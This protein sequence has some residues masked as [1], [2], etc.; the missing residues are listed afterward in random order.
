MMSHLLQS[1]TRLWLRLHSLFH[2]RRLQREME[3]EMR[4]H[5]DQ[6]TRQNLDAGMA[7]EEARYAARRQFGNQTWLKEASRE[8]WRVN[9]IETLM[10]DVRY[11]ARMMWKAPGFTVAAS[12]TLALGIGA[13]TAIFSVV[14]AVLIHSLPYAEAERLV[15]VWEKTRVNEQ[16]QINIGNFLDWKEQ[17]NV[18]TDMAAFVDAR[19]ILTGAGEPEE[20]PAQRA[21]DNLFSVLGV[22]P[23][24]GR[25]FSPNDSKPGLNNVAIISFGLWQRRFGGDP[26]VIG[27]KI[28]LGNAENIVIGVMPPDFK[29]H[30]RK[31]SLTGANAEL[32][33]PLIYTDFQ[34]Q[35]IGRFASAVARIKPGVTYDQASAEMD[36]IG[37]R[38]AEQYKD[39][40]NG[41]TVALVPLRKQLAGEIRLGLFVLTGAVGCVLLIACA[42]VANLLL[43][44]AASRRKEIAVRMALGA[45]RRR[46][47]RLLLTES[48]LLAGL[49]GAMGV[50]LARW[51]AGFLVRLS[52]PELADLRGMELSAPVLGFTFGLTLLTGII[53]GLAPAFELSRPRLSETL[54]EAG[55]GLIGSRGSRRLRSAFVIAEIALAIVLLI[56]AG[57]LLRSF[58]RLQSVEAGFD[59]R[60]VL[61]MRVSLPGRIYDQDNKV[62]NFFSRALEDLKALPGVESV[63]AV[64]FLPFAGPGVATGF[65]VEGRPDSPPD[66]KMTT[67]VLI[68]DQNFFRT[69]RVPLMRGRLF[70]EQETHEMRHVVLINEVLARKYFS[71]EEPLGRRIRIGL[72]N[73][74]TPSEIVGVVGN[75]RQSGFDREAEPMAY[76]PIP[77]STS[78]TMTFVIRTNGEAIALAPATR[79][80]IRALDAQQPV[81]EVRTLENLLGKSVARQRF[82]TWLL[83]VFAATALILAAIGVYSVMAYS[84]TQRS[85]E[86]G[87]RIALGACAPD[88]LKLIV[89]QGMKLALSGVILGLIG[90]I[91]L[92]RLLANLLFGVSATDPLTFSSV[93]ALL[94]G[95][96][97]AA[98]W[99]PARRATKVDPMVA[100]RS[101]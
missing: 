11:G 44:R 63:G 31:N 78:R 84:V 24:L 18:F 28:L 53:F 47:V 91:G 95:V 3:E 15:T 80:A 94:V 8:M 86:I 59:A 96:A 52:P 36:A 70:T 97:L 60:N 55:R 40:N 79:E 37:R 81:A 13:N 76:W 35:R 20:I 98:C 32:W 101:E 38:L 51:G 39:F 9:S 1:L 82:N 77:K 92:T 42:N 73:G 30:I 14:N 33:T 62:V 17:N 69:L 88:V 58:N 56:G 2:R 12:L 74:D 41:C 67:G 72:R 10:Q 50:L 87:I 93:A 64:N 16:N 43:A 100:L 71:G 85:H 54:K 83:A 65:F 4:F 45:G 27:R 89:G 22:S 29:W 21:T 75:V 7:S 5:L 34:R 19:A 90:G 68:V 99:L 46:I 61:T 49:G 25:A 23:M 66:Q 6:Q 48:F 57:L 26:G